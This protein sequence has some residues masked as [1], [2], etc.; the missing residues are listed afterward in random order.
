VDCGGG[1]EALKGS[2]DLELE[3][4]VGVVRTEAL[5]DGPALRVGRDAER[6]RAAREGSRGAVPRSFKQHGGAGDRS[7]I[8]IPDLNDRFS[9][10][11]LLHI[12][13]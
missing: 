2:A 3:V 6:R 4:A 5:S 8:A 1:G 9:G 12:I 10:G 11:A 7:V 13:N